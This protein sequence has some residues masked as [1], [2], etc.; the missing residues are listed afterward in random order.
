MIELT[1]LR[2]DVADAVLDGYRTDLTVDEQQAFAKLRR[3]SDRRSRLV[4]RAVLRRQ[5][6]RKL[7]CAPIDVPLS[8]QMNGKPV[9]DG[10]D[11]Q[12]WHFNVSHSEDVALMAVSDSPVGVDV[13]TGFDGDAMVLAQQFFSHAEHQRVARADNVL[14]AFLSVW[15]AKEAVVK[16]SGHGLR[17]DTRSFC[18]PQASTS[19]QPLLP[20]YPVAQWQGCQI[21]SPSLVPGCSMAVCVQGEHAWQDMRVE[22]YEH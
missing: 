7:G 21:A 12:R 4:T 18:V 19:F 5:L 22:Y 2:T 6:G 10:A 3:A 11:S 1:V 15:T 9:L 20:P 13:E 16:M 17:V 14:A 8:F